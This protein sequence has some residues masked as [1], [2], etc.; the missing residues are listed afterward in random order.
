MT[1]RHLVVLA[2]VAVAVVAPSAA[3]AGAPP[4]AAPNPTRLVAGL[5][6]GSGS[7][8]GPDGA[9]YVTEG[10]AGRVSRV[11][12]KT[13]EVTTFA[14]GLPKS[15][16]GF[17]GAMDVEFIGQT[18]YVLVTVVGPDVGGSDVV[19]IYRVDGPHS[20]TV[21]A[22]IGAFAVA[23]PP[24]TPFVSQP[25]SSTRWSRY[26]GGF[27][28]TDGHHNRVLRVTLDGDVSVLHRVRQHR[29]DRAGGVGQHGVHGRGRPRPAPARE[30]QGGVVR[31]EV[32]HRYG[33]GLRRP[34][35]GRR[36]VRPRPH[37]L[38]AV[39]GHLRR[40]SRGLPGVAE[41][42]QPRQGDRQT[43]PSPSSRTAWTGR[44]RSSSSATPP[45]SSPSPARSGSSAATRVGR[46]GCRIERIEANAAAASDVVARR[47]PGAQAPARGRG[48]R[49][50]RARCTTP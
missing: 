49:S 41:H 14:S 42:R 17:G 34:A 22:D 15:I 21:V 26:R 45:T 7:T 19:G 12:P 33:G 25:V 50:P 20:F 47:E 4:T 32:V 35:A 36:G 13:G 9:L 28:V 38:R 10:A 3:T 40:R 24:S 18:A 39:A 2:T 30:R 11:D 31:A 43:A 8:V 44:P 16:I 29:P 46:A 27:L 1:A 6:G 48:G 37:A 23:N 5:E